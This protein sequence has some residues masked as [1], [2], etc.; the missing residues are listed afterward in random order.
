[1]FAA[2]GVRVTLIDMRPR[3][4]PFVDG[5]LVEALSYHLRE[6]RVMLRLGE[7][8]DRVEVFEDA[9][10]TPRPDS[11]EER[12]ADRERQGAMQRRT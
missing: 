6:R 2:L 4:L 12:E 10:R 3:L 1:M 11:A 7:E 5:E 9:A 8:V